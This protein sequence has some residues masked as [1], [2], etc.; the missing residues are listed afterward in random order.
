MSVVCHFFVACQ[1]LSIGELQ[2]CCKCVVNH[3]KNLGTHDLIEKKDRCPLWIV[4]VSLIVLTTL[5]IDQCL[6]KKVT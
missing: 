3:V 2:V 4:I 6:T 5:T 1:L